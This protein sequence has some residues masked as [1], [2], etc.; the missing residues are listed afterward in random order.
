MGK[1]AEWTDSTNYSKSDP[2]P[3]IPRE[4]TWAN[5]DPP[6][7]MRWRRSGPRLP[8]HRRA[9]PNLRNGSPT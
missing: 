5:A 6:S 3:R 4:W 1:A 9:S 7:S 2:M 8:L